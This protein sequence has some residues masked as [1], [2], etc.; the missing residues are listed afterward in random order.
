[1]NKISFIYLVLLTWNFIFRV[2]FPCLALL[3]LCGA[4]LFLFSW[5]LPLVHLMLHFSSP[6]FYFLY[7][8]LMRLHK[9]HISVK[10]DLI[11]FFLNCVALWRSFFTTPSVTHYV[12]QCYFFCAVLWRSFFNCPSMRYF[13]QFFP[14]NNVF[15]NLCW[16][17]HF[18]RPSPTSAAR[19]LSLDIEFILLPFLPTTKS[20]KEWLIYINYETNE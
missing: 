8:R 18:L 17:R 5:R 7:M 3:L 4:A 11:R 10:N 19:F 16:D 9:T 6:R 12:Q 13:V 2:F 14:S 15:F 1:M 20:S